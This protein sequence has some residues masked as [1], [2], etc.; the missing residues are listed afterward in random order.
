MSDVMGVG[1][2]SSNRQIEILV[3]ESNPAEIF[4][5]EMAF[6]KAGL[7]SGFR[8]VSDGEDAL[9]YVR[10]EGRYADVPT[11]DLIFLDLSLPKING[12]DVLKA[13]ML[14]LDP[15]DVERAFRR[16]A[17]ALAGRSTASGLHVAIDGKT[18]RGSFDSFEDRKAAHVLSAFASG[19][20][21]T[22]AHLDCGEKSNEIPAVQQ[23]VKELGLPPGALISVD[24]MHCQKKPSRPPPLPAI[25]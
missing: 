9:C 7:T 16:H 19:L 2:P 15:D 20:A 23:L 5:T 10:K 6:K 21:L 24:A 8:S 3:V 11:P 14:H 22:L 13:I 12:L 25:T 4:L 1:K 18:L 17:A